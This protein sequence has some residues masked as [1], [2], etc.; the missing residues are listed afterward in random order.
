MRLSRHRIPPL[1]ATS[2]VVALLAWP[3]GLVAIDVAERQ[4]EDTS[5]DLSRVPGSPVWSTPLLI[6]ITVTAEWEKVQHVVSARALR[7]DRF[8]WQ[9]MHL[10]DWD[11]V[12]SPLREESLR[13]IFTRYEGL[14]ASPR[15]WQHMTAA[16]WDDVPHPVR[17]VA[18]VRMLEH[19]RAYYDLGAA[20]NLS[21]RLVADT[22]AA[23]VM[24]ESYFEHRS[25]NT[26]QWG[27]RDLGLAAASDR[28]REKLGE[29][30]AAGRVDF[31][32]SHDD[33]FNPWHATRFVAVW[34]QMLLSRL[35]GDLPV[36]IGAYHRGERNARDDKGTQYLA[37]VERRRAFFL[38]R[39]SGP[40][41]WRYLWSGAP[42][43]SITLIPL[44]PHALM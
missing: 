18:F 1:V 16:D 11:R 33:Y 38:D 37:D 9:R 32:L 30:Y 35:D 24:A 29:L 2:S 8:L 31:T 12:P 25:T 5:I 23:I 42:R 44:I 15:R 20:H 34:M 40:P 27:N 26:N 19:W 36:A 17:I 7:A 21:P 28:A 41:A 14:L 39:A 6:P 13:A 3:A 22:L 4:L 43:S 10:D